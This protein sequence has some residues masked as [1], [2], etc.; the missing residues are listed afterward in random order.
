[1][2]RPVAENLFRG[3]GEAAR[4]LAGRRRADGRLRFPY[5]QGADAGDYE[6]I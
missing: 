2:P 3:E 5:P 4:L 1:M 6:L